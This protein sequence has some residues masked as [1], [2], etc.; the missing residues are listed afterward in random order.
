MPEIEF[1][2]LIVSD[3]MNKKEKNGWLRELG[4]MPNVFGELKKKVQGILNAKGYLDS[5]SIK[6][7]SLLD[8]HPEYLSEKE[9]WKDGD[10]PLLVDEADEMPGHEGETQLYVHYHCSRE[11]C[12]NC[13]SGNP[14][15]RGHFMILETKKFSGMKLYGKVS[16]LVTKKKTFLVLHPIPVFKLYKE[17]NG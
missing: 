11:G 5:F 13:H 2:K 16:E 3:N 7:G 4:L 8:W 15:I 1:S 9:D 12:K 17:D 6:K 10:A 14:T